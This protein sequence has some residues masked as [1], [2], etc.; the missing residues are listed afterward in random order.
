M[1]KLK[2]L[3]AV[4]LVTVLAASCLAGC[5]GKEKSGNST[6]D[7]EIAYW[8]SGLGTKW[9]DAVIAAFEAKYPEYHVTYSATASNTAV[10]AAFRNEDSDTIDLYMATKEYDTE[11][12]E[13]LDDVLDTTVE[14]ESKTIREKIDSAYLELE[15][16]TDGNVYQLTYG[17]GAM[18]FVYNKELF[19][20]AGVR[21]LP[22]TTD[23]LAT[24]CDTLA[25][26]NITPICHYASTGYWEYMTEAWFAQYDGMEYYTN[27]FYA[28]TEEDGT[29]PSKE[30]FTKQDGRYEAMK[31]CEKIVTPDYVLSGSNTNDHVTMQ[32]KFLQGEAA[33]MINGS[34]L[35]NEMSDVGSVDNFS[36]MKTPVISTITD[37]LTTV[38]KETDLRKLITAI[39][40]VTDGEKDITE[41]QDGDNYVVD[42][43]SVS[44]A[45]WEYVRKARNT[46]PSNFAGE[47]MFIPTY[48]NAKEGAKEFIKFMYSDEGYK[49]YTDTLHA[50]LPL[51]MSEGT[52]DTSD[53]NVYETAVNDLL[54]KAEQQPTEYIMSKHPIFYEGGARSYANFIFISKFC[55]NNAAD[56]LSA[57]EAWDEVVKAVNND[58]ENNWLANIGE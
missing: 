12:L 31:A 39:D 35:A 2:R 36:I 24:V 15:K 51:S 38:K 55:S 14:G 48:S 52:I 13:P 47:T 33:M 32:T 30:I 40:A 42:G 5:G 43:L 58:Y 10:V 6:T 7:I 8:N 27:N 22:R 3:L 46:V 26:A 4:T 41:Y 28:C 21:T 11:Y 49:V 56:R 18:G 23:E 53:W 17:G 57:A 9:L 37:K 16:A 44:A 25:A 54:M 34:W 20:E 45:D 19:E 29:S 1:N 50:G